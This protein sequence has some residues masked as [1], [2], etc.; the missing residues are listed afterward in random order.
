[1]GQLR[2]GDTVRFHRVTQD[3]AAQNVGTETFDKDLRHHRAQ[4]KEPRADMQSVQS[5][6]REQRRQEGA[7]LGAG[8]LHDHPGEVPRL[9]LQL[10]LFVREVPGVLEV[11]IG[12]ALIADALEL[13]YAEAV[14]QYLGAL[15]RG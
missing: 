2:P 9:E 10:P 15:G 5:D 8:A 1:M 6:D 7:A 13:G 4:P 14:R 12:H 11:S 3:E